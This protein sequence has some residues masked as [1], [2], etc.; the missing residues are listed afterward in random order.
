MVK[1]AK[2]NNYSFLLLELETAVL[3][4]EHFFE[5]NYLHPLEVKI[6]RN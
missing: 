1:F 6:S 2:K 3:T 5:K 4:L